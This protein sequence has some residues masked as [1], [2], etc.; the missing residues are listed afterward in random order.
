VAPLVSPFSPYLD[1]DGG[2]G[3]H[4]RCLEV[5]PAQLHRVRGDDDAGVLHLKPRHER[6]HQLA[7]VHRLLDGRPLAAEDDD[8]DDDNG[9]ADAGHHGDDD[10]EQVGLGGAGVQHVTVDVVVRAVFALLDGRPSRRG[11]VRLWEKNQSVY[12]KLSGK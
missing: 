6:R 8:D 7:G 11:N 1:I 12:Q 10:P 3:E 5:H 9:E 2:V 4:A